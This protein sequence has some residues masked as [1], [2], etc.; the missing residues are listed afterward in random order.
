MRTK[1]F[2]IE[3]GN[4]TGKSTLIDGLKDKFDNLTTVYSIPNEYNKLRIN[5]YS[6]W[7]D[8]ASLFY[9]LSANLETIDKINSNFIVFDR[10]ILSTFSIYLSRINQSKWNEILPLFHEFINLM[11]NINKIYLLTANE[12]IRLS[13]INEKSG[14]DKEADLKEVEFEKI[15][16]EARIFLLNN[17]HLNYQEIDTSNL[18]KNEVLDI[19]YKSIKNDN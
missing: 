11:P 5:T 4:S 12:N 8:K 19:V 17:S 16:D 1:Y 15:K 9:Y 14:A 3:G 2:I 10:S 13:R 7:S 6:K 18:T